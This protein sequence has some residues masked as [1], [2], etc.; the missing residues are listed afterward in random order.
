MLAARPVIS[1]MRSYT[2]SVMVES[3]SETTYFPA[4]QTLAASESYKRSCMPALFGGHLHFEEAILDPQCWQA[5]GNGSPTLRAFCSRVAA[6]A[7]IHSCPA[8]HN[9]A[10]ANLMTA[11]PLHSTTL[12]GGQAILLILSGQQCLPCKPILL[13]DAQ[14]RLEYQ[15]VWHHCTVLECTPVWFR[16]SCTQQ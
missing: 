11:L 13:G 6:L 15:G 1:M 9:S 3:P 14:I 7:V 2:V 5:H 4:K 12:I 16:P 8:R 10:S